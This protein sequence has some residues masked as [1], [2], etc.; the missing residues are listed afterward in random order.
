MKLV[1]TFPIVVAMLMA[2]FTASTNLAAATPDDGATAEYSPEEIQQF[3][4]LHGQHLPATMERASAMDAKLNE[5]R[6]RALTMTTSNGSGSNNYGTYAAQLAAR[7]NLIKALIG[8]T[9]GSVSITTSEKIL[10]YVPNE[11]L[12]DNHIDALEDLADDFEDE[13]DDADDDRIEDLAEDIKDL[14]DDVDDLEDY[15]T[16]KTDDLKEEWQELGGDVAYFAPAPE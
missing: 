13:A 15:L 9:Y 2:V 11:Q 8:N 6:Q 4:Q 12:L 3:A 16:Y 7:A 1:H 5:I 14:A 10:L